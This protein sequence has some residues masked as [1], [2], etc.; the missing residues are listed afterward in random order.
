M[1]DLFFEYRVGIKSNKGVF[2]TLVTSKEN[3]AKDIDRIVTA[4]QEQAVLKLEKDGLRDMQVMFTDEDMTDI[5]RIIDHEI[6]RASGVG[7]GTIE[8]PLHYKSIYFQT[9]GRIVAII[10]KKIGQET[11]IHNRPVI[12]MFSSR[13]N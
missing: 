2:E 1:I 10:T 12:A 3:R 9:K 11:S 7:E 8:I 6:S 4:I 13:R 5:G